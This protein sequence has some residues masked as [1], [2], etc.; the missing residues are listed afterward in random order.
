MSCN[1]C[2]ITVN[3]QKVGLVVDYLAGGARPEYKAG[4]FV[5]RPQNI[6]MII[7]ACKIPATGPSEIIIEPFFTSC[8]SVE[9]STPDVIICFNQELDPACDW[10]TGVTITVDGAPVNILS[11]TPVGDSDPWG[12]TYEVDVT[13]NFGETIV[14]DY[15]AVV[16]DICALSGTKLGDSTETGTAESDILPVPGY[17]IWLNP[18]NITV[19]AGLVTGWVNDSSASLGSTADLTQAGANIA[20]STQS[21]FSVVESTDATLKNLVAVTPFLISSGFTVFGVGRIDGTS[22]SIS[23]L[24][25]TPVATGDRA[26]FGAVL[27]VAGDDISTLT[28]L[29]NDSLP[30][31]FGGRFDTGNHRAKI[32]GEVAW[33][34]SVIGIAQNWNYGKFL[35]TFTPNNQQVVGWLGEVIVYPSA[36]SDADTDIVFSY[37]TSKWNLAASIVS[38]IAGT[39]SPTIAGQRYTSSLTDA[40]V[41]DPSASTINTVDSDTGKYYA[42][43]SIVRFTSTVNDIFG[44]GWKRSDQLA[45]VTQTYTIGIWWSDATGSWKFNSDL[46]GSNGVDFDVQPATPALGINVEQVFGVSLDCSANKLYLSYNGSWLTTGGGASGGDP[47]GGNGWDISNPASEAILYSFSKAGNATLQAITPQ[48]LPSG[49]TDVT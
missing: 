37:L 1:P 9:S 41:N 35:Q 34:D 48:Y 38:W 15:D 21:G 19:S 2:A 39:G 23:S 10:E 49:Y 46:D 33:T 22:S 18:T 3:P 31:V 28:L 27:T 42:E 20:E 45:D 32:S 13:L 7:A 26:L 24:I 16:G 12:Y 8:I 4:G 40:S 44:F 29:T 25:D 43:F 5:V 36:L 11:V 6:G 17:S 14:W 47:S 30:H